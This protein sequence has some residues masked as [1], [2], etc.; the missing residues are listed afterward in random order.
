VIVLLSKAVIKL[1]ELLAVEC[2]EEG[3]CLTGMF[4]KAKTSHRTLGGA[5]DL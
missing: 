1:D 5:V 4:L 2:A 3:R